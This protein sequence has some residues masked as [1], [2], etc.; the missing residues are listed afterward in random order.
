MPIR[1]LWFNY[2][3]ECI[4]VFLFRA[5]EVSDKYTIAV[6]PPETEDELEQYP[7]TLA[8][9]DHAF[10]ILL[11]YQDIVFR[12]VYSE[13]NA[14]VELEPKILAGSIIKDKGEKP[15]R[16]NRGNA[17]TIIE[18]E[19]GIRFED[20]PRFGE[21]DEIRKIANAYKHDDGYSGTYEEIVPDSGWLFGYRETRYKLTWDKAYRSI[22]AVG[23]FLGVLPG[24]RQEFRRLRPKPEDEATL[25]A[26]QRAWDYLT[27][28]GALGH[29][30]GKPVPGADE[31]GGYSAT[32]ELCG[33]SFW[34]EDEDLLYVT[35][36]IDRAKC[37][38]VP[39]LQQ[40]P[41]NEA[42]AS[43]KD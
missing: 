27:K 5:F 41:P 20:L 23:E 21:V 2:K 43:H 14:L 9:I 24:E 37:P 36:A 3:M 8:E 31:Q 19:Y 16:L 39:G 40:L 12:A 13:L 32:C 15:P 26:R 29:Q 18:R 6:R 10:D 4:E 17:R 28:R 25:Q 35:A 34:A 38:G 22:Q 42:T 33:K 7:Q 30:L 1:D 11:G